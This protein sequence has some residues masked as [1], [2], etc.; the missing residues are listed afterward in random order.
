MDHSGGIRG[1]SRFP[2]YW[3]SCLVRACSD[4]SLKKHGEALNS[5]ILHGMPIKCPPHICY[6][7]IKSS[8]PKFP[9]WSGVKLVYKTLKTKF[10][11]PNVTKT[12]PFTCLPLS[13]S[14]PLMPVANTLSLLLTISGQARKSLPL[15]KQQTWVLSDKF[16]TVLT[17]LL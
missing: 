15:F 10:V 6:A 17:R 9:T 3:P 16:N 12:S 13:T 14:N 8:I 1:S 11:M 2:I 4:R 5:N 7:D